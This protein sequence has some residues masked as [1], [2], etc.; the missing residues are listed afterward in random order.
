MLVA[1]LNE[2]KFDPTNTTGVSDSLALAIPRA[3]D[4]TGVTDT[5]YDHQQSGTTEDPWTLVDPH[6]SDSKA[7]PL[8][9]GKTFTIPPGIN[10]DGSEDSSVNESLNVSTSINKSSFVVEDEDLKLRGLAY[11]NEF[12]YVAKEIKKRKVRA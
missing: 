6:S 11:G 3:N 1:D 7:R 8:K 4:E 12:A 10:E 5:T 9:K 2:S